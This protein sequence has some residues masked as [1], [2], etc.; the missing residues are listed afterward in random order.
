MPSRRIVFKW[1]C[2]RP[3][4][5]GQNMADLV[6][7]EELSLCSFAPRLKIKLEKRCLH[8]DQ[9][10]VFCFSLSE[11]QLATLAA[12]LESYVARMTAFR[13]LKGTDDEPTNSD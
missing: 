12:S 11:N 5:E 9:E 13:A 1:A 3:G 7:S 10:A 6:V 4:E 2:D 8:P